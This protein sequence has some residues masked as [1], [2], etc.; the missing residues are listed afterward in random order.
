MDLA[1][2]LIGLSSIATGLKAST[3]TYRGQTIT[4]V[5]VPGAAG[6]GPLQISFAAKDNLVVVGYT[7]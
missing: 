7:D 2:S 6:R 3:E 4:L 5:S 1:G